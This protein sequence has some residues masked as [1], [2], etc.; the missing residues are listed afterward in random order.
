[1]GIGKSSNGKLISISG[2]GYFVRKLRYADY[3]EAA[4][5]VPAAVPVMHVS[6]GAD[7]S[8]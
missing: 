6:G 5:L 2:E 7:F 4:Y 1:M 8:N 3:K